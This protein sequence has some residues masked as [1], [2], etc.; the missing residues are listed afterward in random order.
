M[1][2]NEAVSRRLVELMQERGM[3][4]YQL[5]M[6]SGV[7]KSTIGNLVN[8]AYSPIWPDGTQHS[9]NV[10]ARTREECEEKLKA[11]I[12][13]MN[14]ER[15]N[16]KEQLAGIAPPE[17]LTNKQHKLWDY[18]RLHPEVTEFSTI[19]KRTGLARN[20]VKKH[21]G[22]VAGMLGRK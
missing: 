2:L 11:L 21:Y 17:K 13:E 8:C 6:K 3:T 1:Q 12:A 14:E 20:T 18:M 9:R 7:P 5:Y 16:L 15:K 10:Y 19:A 22:M 4:Q